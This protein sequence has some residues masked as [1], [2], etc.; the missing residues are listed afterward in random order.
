MKCDEGTGHDTL[1]STVLSLSGNSVGN[2]DYSTE[3]ARCL[4]VWVFLLSAR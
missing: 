4:F 3:L 2:Q 1:C